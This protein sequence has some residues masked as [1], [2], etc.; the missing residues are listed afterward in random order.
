MAAETITSIRMSYMSMAAAAAAQAGL[1]AIFEGSTSA[2]DVAL[3]CDVMATTDFVQLLP[4]GPS[5]QLT[6][7]H[8]IGLRVALLVTDA[9][10][11]LALD[12]PSVAA[13]AALEATQVQYAIQAVGLPNEVQADILK[14]APA[15]GPLT[16]D[17][18]AGLQAVLTQILPD[19]L[20][21]LP[22]APDS[23]EFGTYTVGQVSPT[24]SRFER[25][26]LINKAMQAIAGGNSLRAALAVAGADPDVT[27]LVYAQMA[28][29]SDTTIDAPPA[30]DRQQ[31]ANLWL[32]GD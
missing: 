31:A 24:I 5:M 26:R 7:R 29:L 9:K 20:K 17:S 3:L 30:A 19:H 27:R 6:V 23:S 1:S 11:N 25:A 2:T 22:P 32:S 28:G 18:F 15:T 4:A 21:T 14:A 8:G 12:I 16:P 13:S 10:A